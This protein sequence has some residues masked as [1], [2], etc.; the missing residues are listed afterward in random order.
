MYY[1]TILDRGTGAYILILNIAAF[2]SLE[3]RATYRCMGPILFLLN[4][5]LTDLRGGSRKNRDIRIY[6]H[7]HMTTPKFLL[8]NPEMVLE[9]NRK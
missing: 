6:D 8:C 7:A 4:I 3:D 1:S 2:S 5:T 9:F